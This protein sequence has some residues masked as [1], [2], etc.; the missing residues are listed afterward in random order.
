MLDFNEDKKAVI[1]FYPKPWS[2]EKRGR[3][4]YALLYLERMIRHL[5]LEIILIDEQTQ[6]DYLPIIE[7]VKDR[8]FLVCVSAMTGYQITGAIKFS[9]IIKNCSQA[10]VVWGGWHATLLPE[11]VLMENYV[12]FVIKGQGENAL[13]NLIKNLLEQKDIRQIKS[14]A[15]KQAG[16]AIVNEMDNFVDIKQFPEVNYQ[17]IDINEYVFKSVYSER[18]LGYFASHGCPFSC[19]FCCVAK[20]YGRRW[21]NKDITEIIKDLKYFKES[22]QIDSVTFDD[23]NFFVNKDFTLR[24]CQEMIASGLDLKWD[25]SA[26]AALF[27]RLFNDEEINLV[28]QA[29]CRQIYV[30]AE[31]GDQDIL[32]LIDKKSKVED[33]LNFV[34]LLN[35]HKITPMLS[36]ML[37]FPVNPDRD[38]KLTLDMIR[39]AKLIDK[40]LRARL[41]FY[42]PYP[43]TA[44][45]QKSIAKGLIPP[46]KLEE[47]ANYTLRKFRAPWAVR[48]YRWEIEIFAN[49]YLPLVNPKFYQTIPKKFRPAVYVINKIFYPLAYLRFKYN[50]LKFP[51]EAY[52]FITSL[53]FF[54]KIFKTKFA[55]GY[56][57]YLD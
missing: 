23:D 47:W 43:G 11:Q 27:L 13:F 49:F 34:K 7:K 29:G 24:L 10:K 25:T 38:I 42:T 8:L 54:N 39:R 15:Y 33:N 20:V 1:L 2:G 16:I 46:R 14:L 31:S 36:T 44:L 28:H 26:H 56:E 52:L 50:F 22:A 18:C 57:S 9:K 45:Y 55:L 5:G 41:F 51:F 4:P 35:A 17:L 3:I 53:R 6:A 32:D 40:T 37:C 48:D 19:A 30:G 12:D 21:F